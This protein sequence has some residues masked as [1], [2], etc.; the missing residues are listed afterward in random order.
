MTKGTSFT[1]CHRFLDQLKYF[2]CWSFVH[3]VYNWNN[4]P[5]Q[6][7]TFHFG[8]FKSQF[9]LQWEG[10]EL[11]KSTWNYIHHPFNF[12]NVT[13]LHPLR[14]D[15]MVNGKK[16]I[17]YIKMERK[18]T[19]WLRFTKAFFFCG[20][21]CTRAEANQDEVGAPGKINRWG[22]SKIVFC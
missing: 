5:W 1:H 7:K 14:N 13:W 8:R 2:S 6:S 11:F 4:F 22:P 19:F 20:I 18:C 21:A 10:L 17:F 12:C 15:W 9:R 3:G 16:I